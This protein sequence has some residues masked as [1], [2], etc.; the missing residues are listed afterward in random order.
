MRQGRPVPGGLLRA[1]PINNQY[2]PMERGQ[3]K[4]ELRGDCIVCSEDRSYEAPTSPP[5]ESDRGINIAIR[6]HRANGPERFD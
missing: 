6:N 3:S 5:R 4:N 1:V 2:T